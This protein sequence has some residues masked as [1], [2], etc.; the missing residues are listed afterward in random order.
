VYG[1]VWSFRACVF[2]SFPD[3]ELDAHEGCSGSDVG[4][5]L[6]DLFGD[7]EAH[8]RPRH[9][10]AEITDPEV[11]VELR[12]ELLNAALAVLIQ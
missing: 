7:D 3:R 2:P 9:A 10:A 5:P 11:L 12:P 1:I 8:M 6:T 4:E